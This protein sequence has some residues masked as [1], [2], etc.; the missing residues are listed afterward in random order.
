[1]SGRSL[2]C[3]LLLAFVFICNCSD[4]FAYIEKESVEKVGD[5]K[6]KLQDFSA[7]GKS[8]TK[9]EIFRQGKSV[10][11]NYYSHAWVFSMDRQELSFEGPVKSP[12][13][14]SDL[15]GD[16]IPDLVIQTWN[17]GAYC[18]YSYEIYSLGKH[19]RRIWSHPAGCGHLKIDTSKGNRSC[20]DIED[21]SFAFD[22]P[23]TVTS[24]P[25]PIVHY[26]W[27]GRKFALDQAKM[28]RGAD[29]NL[30]SGAKDKD[31]T[32]DIFQRSMIALIYSGRTKDSLNLAL[33]HKDMASQ[34]LPSLLASLRKSSNFYRILELN[35]R[36]DFAA[37]EKLSASFK[38]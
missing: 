11:L 28:R 35:D 19:F 34:S 33:R 3:A 17:G 24:A 22:Y 4:A 27:A 1:V 37:L 20:L 2:S 15:T 36:R 9:L 7:G 31:I 12:A 25:R 8:G 23:W 26:V 32:D 14:I 38:P 6:V 16:G 13:L 18:C 21:A 10:F 30:A 5:Y 29:R